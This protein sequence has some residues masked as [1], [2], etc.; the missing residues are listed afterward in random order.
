MVADKVCALPSR[1]PLERKVLVGT[2]GRSQIRELETSNV[3]LHLRSVEGADHTACGADAQAAEKV[4]ATARG[5]AHEI[6]LII[7]NLAV[8]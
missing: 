4:I 8:Q 3:R 5:M 7:D 1:F 6:H 2:E